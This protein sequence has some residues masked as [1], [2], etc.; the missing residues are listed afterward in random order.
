MSQLK[1]LLLLARARG[2]LDSISCLLIYKE[3]R[4]SLTLEECTTN[5]KIVHKT[6]H[7]GKI[8]VVLS[9]WASFERRFF[10]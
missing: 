4:H 7:L 1:Q 8:I 2:S 6:S 3:S 10:L 9:M 5:T